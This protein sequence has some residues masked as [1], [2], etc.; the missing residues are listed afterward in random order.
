[1]YR[2]RFEVFFEDEF[3]HPFMIMIM[4]IMIIIIIIIIIYRYNNIIHT[5]WIEDELQKDQTGIQ[6]S[7]QRLTRDYQSQLSR[8]IRSH[9]SENREKTTDFLKHFY[10]KLRN[11]EYILYHQHAGTGTGT[12]T[13]ADCEND[14]YCR[15]T[16]N[17]TEIKNSAHDLPHPRI[18]SELQRKYE[19]NR[20]IAQPN[21]NG[22]T[23]I[24]YK[25]YT[26]I[27]EKSEFCIQFQ[28]TIYGRVITLYFITFPES[29]ISVCNRSS[30][31]SGGSRCAAE[32]AVYQTYAYKAFI[33]LSIVTSMAD[34]ECSEK[35]LNVYFYMT[36]FKKQ[37]PKQSASGETDT[38]LSAIHVNTGL[39]RNCETHGEIVV[40][41]T[42]EWFKVFIH[43]SMHNFNMD[44]ID[45][46]LRAANEQLRRT[47]CIPHDDIL[48]FETYTEAWARIINTIFNVYFVSA[49]T[50]ATSATSQA[51]FI[52]NVR[53]KLTTNAL[54]YAHQAVKVLNIMGLTYGNITIQSPE[55]TE[56]SRKRYAENTNVYAYY[57]LG[58]I[59][60]VYSLPFISWCC[61]NNRSRVSAIR[62]SQHPSNLTKFVDF[63]SSAARDPVMLSMVAFIEKAATTTATAATA[64]TAV[65]TKTMR[66]TMD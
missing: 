40:Y 42:E 35:S 43:E 18:L 61:E 9:L 51:H 45:L 48:L 44:F 12:G 37:R 63:I 49:A 41:R 23:Y 28:A 59:L 27:R 21:D 20:G 66:M 47:F 25:V 53:E 65:V 6:E 55:N 8:N 17:I 2:S 29:H 15:L 57:I 30:S 13:G 32:T 33:W 11:A 31:G 5:M 24:P 39:T 60:S 46:D 3:E 22:D 26:Y 19:H 52:R 64:A 7:I 10:H 56:V 1:M 50:S 34:K 38:V 14:A 16:F 58:G 62:F 4:I 36:P 54:F